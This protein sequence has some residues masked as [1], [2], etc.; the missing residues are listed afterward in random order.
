MKQRGRTCRGALKTEG[1][2]VGVQRQGPPDRG[3]SLLRAPSAT[4]DAGGWQL[5]LS[6]VRGPSEGP[7]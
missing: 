3:V 7:P 6:R 5:E 2:A 1:W 4:F